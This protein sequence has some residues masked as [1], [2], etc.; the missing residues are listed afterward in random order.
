MH[1]LI[2]LATDGTLISTFEH[3]ELQKPC[4]L[5]VT[6]AGQ[7]LVCGYSSHTVIQIDGE[8]RHKL[9]TLASQKDGLDNPASVCYNTN[10]RQMIVGLTN[11]NKIIVMDLK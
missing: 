3:S 9:A 6:P 1:K 5:D 10:T 11:N 2:T 7:V 4:G 8:G